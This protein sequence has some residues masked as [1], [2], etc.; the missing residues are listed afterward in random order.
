[1]AAKK[2]RG[3]GRAERI[4]TERLRAEG[5]E[6]VTTAA[7]EPK[8]S[9]AFVEFAAPLLDVYRREGRVTPRDFKHALGLALVIWNAA[10]LPD[11]DD[12]LEAV[13]ASFGPGPEEVRLQLE[14]LLTTLVESR[15]STFASDRRAI[16]DFQV[17]AGAPGELRVSV[18]YTTLPSPVVR[19]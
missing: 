4:L 6:V 8:A 12:L 13:R 1:M 16:S 18:A 3:V 17:A 7:G 2:G 19:A 11:G 9:E 15:R 14:L 10:L 5:N